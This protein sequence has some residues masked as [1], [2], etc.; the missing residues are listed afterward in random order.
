M[1]VSQFNA[2]VALAFFFCAAAQAA[3]IATVPVGNPGNAA[4][5][6][7]SGSVGYLYH[8]G[9]YEVTND[10]YVEFL[11]SVDPTGGNTLALYNTSM[12]SDA[13]G[14]IN[15]NGG[16]PNGSIYEIKPGRG[17]NPVVFV[18]WYDSIRFANWMHN[19]MGDGDTE[20]GAY[21]LGALGGG[22]VP[23]D[24]SSIT[25]NPAARWWVPS[26]NG[27]FQFRKLWTRTRHR[28]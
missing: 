24:G 14:G 13:R 22:G 15:F 17:N 21:T 19:G 12:A 9:K 3:T 26:D 5:T 8:I 16:A 10:Q 18:S 2:L 1:K 6:T 23:I 11:N 20:D 7:G 28:D 25:R 27:R 4:D